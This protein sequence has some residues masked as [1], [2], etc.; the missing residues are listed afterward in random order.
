MDSITLEVRDYELDAQGIVNNGVYFGYLEHAR[1]KWLAARNIDFVALHERGI[2][3]V[4]VEAKVVY[5]QPLKSG[6]RFRVV[7]DV[8]KRGALRYVFDQRIERVDDGVE[9][10]RS[11]ITAVSLKDGRPAKIP[12]LEEAFA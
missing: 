8:R 4:V 12:E 2:D 3:P 1:H 7:T 10:A 6:D 9:C 5:V 11:E